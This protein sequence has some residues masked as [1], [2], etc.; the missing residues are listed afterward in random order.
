MFIFRAYDEG[1]P[2]VPTFH[3]VSPEST[4]LLER[5]NDHRSR[6]SGSRSREE[7][8]TAMST[9]AQRVE[10]G[11]PEGDGKVRQEIQ[12]KERRKQWSWGGIAFAIS[13]RKT[14]V[15]RTIRK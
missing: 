10:G 14:K 4:A 2:K 9:S 1:I 3:G 5:L 8:R 6:T 11:Y 13:L 12:H 15:T 7:K